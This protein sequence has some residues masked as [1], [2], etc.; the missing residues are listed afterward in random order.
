MFI[1]SV[2]VSAEAGGGGHGMIAFRREKHV[3]KGGPSGG[4]GGRGG[5]IVVVCDAHASTLLDLHYRRHYKAK[6]GQHGSGSDR[7]G[8][9]SEDVIIRVPAGTLV[10][11]DE[12][13][14]LLAD[15]TQAEERVVVCRGGR[16]GRGNA[17]FAT[18]TIQAPRTAEDGHPGEKRRLRF[19]LKVM[20]DVGLVGRPNAGKS[21]LLSVVS[22]AH[23][24]IADYPFTTTEPHLG[25]VRVGDYESFVLADIPGLIEGAH[26]GKGLGHRFLRHVQRARVL[27]YLI[28]ITEADPAAVRAELHSELERFDPQL[29]RRPALVTLSKIDLLTADSDRQQKMACF[30][31]EP[32]LISAV[33]GEGMPVWTRRV[34]ELHK[35]MQAAE[36]QAST[37]EGDD[38]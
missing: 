5:D 20:A 2:V 34:H 26:R 31:A 9:S 23:P 22:A 24:K 27:V 6:R 30:D 18:P 37:S 32:L 12:S 28:D 10:Y 3:P 13:G 15:L 25:L 16:G 8:R 35:E 1:D 29:T 21:T 17:A 36:L 19:E 11:D 4:N 14:A 38:T 33:T 7:H